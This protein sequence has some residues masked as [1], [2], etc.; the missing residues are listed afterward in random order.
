MNIIEA[1]KNNPVRVYAIIVALL[2]II[3]IYV[4]TLPVGLLLT[5]AAAILGVSEV[6]RQLVT[7]TRKLDPQA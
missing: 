2:P 6:P 7:P 4:T 5:L 3:A 1:I